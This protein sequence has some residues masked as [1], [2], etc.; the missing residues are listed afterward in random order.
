SEQ[1]HSSVEKAALLA[2]FGRANLRRIAV[3][4]RRAM[5]PDALAAAIGE[6]RGR[7]RIPCA[8][9][10]T[11]GTTATTALDPIGAIAGIARERNTWLHVDAAMAGS[12]MMLP[13]C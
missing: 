1:A 3:D 4:E 12:A 10:A 13:E 6:D 5:R 8:V 2:G 9:V 7:G 11:T